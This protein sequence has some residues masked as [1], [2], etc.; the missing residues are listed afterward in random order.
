MHMNNR[1]DETP[2]DVKGGLVNAKNKEMKTMV[3]RKLSPSQRIK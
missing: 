1:I 3:M 2:M